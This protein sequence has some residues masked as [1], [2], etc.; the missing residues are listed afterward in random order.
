M[1]FACYFCNS[2]KKLFNCNKCRKIVCNECKS[3]SFHKDANN[4]IFCKKKSKKYRTSN[5]IE[6]NQ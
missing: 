1:F 3:F 6:N 2:K 4:C 5:R